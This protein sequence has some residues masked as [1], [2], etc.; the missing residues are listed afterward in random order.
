MIDAGSWACSDGITTG[1]SLKLDVAVATAE[2]RLG[3]FVIGRGPPQG[4]VNTCLV[5]SSTEVL[6][7]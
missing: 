2:R 5:N 6:S 4:H 1:R 7:R 3:N